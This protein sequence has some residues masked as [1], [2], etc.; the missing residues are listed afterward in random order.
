M[1]ST[2]IE[3]MLYIEKVIKITADV[4]TQNGGVNWNLLKEKN[5][6]DSAVYNVWNDSIQTYILVGNN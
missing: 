3:K 4:I 1:H 6:L 5:N 2:A